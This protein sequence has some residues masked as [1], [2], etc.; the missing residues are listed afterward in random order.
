[1]TPTALSAKIRYYTR[2]NT[3]TL[4]DAE[5]LVLENDV[6]DELAAILVQ[7]NE[8]VFVIPQLGD[9]VASSVTAREYSLPDDVLGGLV[10][11]QA[12]FITAS[13][14]DYVPAIPY[15]GGMVQLTQDLNGLTEAKIVN[16]FSNQI[17]KYV[18][19]RRGIYLLSGTIIAVT[20][21]LKI[22]SRIFPADL[23][24]VSGSTDLS[25]DPTTTSFGMPRVLHELWARRASIVWKSSRPKPIELSPLEKT[26]EPD[27]ERML[28][29]LE[30]D[31]D[32]EEIIGTVPSDGN[33]YQF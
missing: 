8:Q 7:R 32:Q 19:T 22:L 6:K 31:D 3:T 33:G 11:V 16:K 30:L 20:S 27:L 26:Y 29:T 12:A 13:P 24:S 18:L 5:L 4:P 21:G 15:P 14:L 17:P 10:T 28:E 9:L 25:V 2:T 1:M 23:A